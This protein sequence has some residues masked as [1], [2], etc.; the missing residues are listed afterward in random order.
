MFK[1]IKI[2]ITLILQMKLII[3]TVPL[4]LEIIQIAGLFEI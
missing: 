4:M 3:L 1:T 2:D